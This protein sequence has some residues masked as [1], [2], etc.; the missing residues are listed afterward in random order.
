M[1]TRISLDRLGRAAQRWIATG[2]PWTNVYGL[3]R[4]LLAMGT[5]GT[6]TFSPAEVLFTPAAGLPPPPYCAGLSHASLFCVLP[7]DRLDLAR[8][9]AIAILLVTA[10]GWLPRYTA[11]PHWWVSFS[12]ASSISIPD[13]GD[14]VTTVLTLLLLPIALADRRRW[15]WT[16]PPGRPTAARPTATLVAMAATV[17]I[18]IQVAGIYLQASVAKLGVTE[19]RDGTALYYWLNDPL[20]G[21][22][23]W[24]RGLL[25]P[26]LSFGP[27][28][29][30]LTWGTMALEFCLAIA[31]VLPRRRWTPLLV[32]GLLLHSGIAV[33]MGLWSFALAMF[34]AL[35][36]YLRPWEWPFATP[37]LV[38]RSSAAVSRALSV[39]RNRW[40]ATRQP[41]LVQRRAES[42]QR[43]GQLPVR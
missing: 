29:A 43:T 40:A 19:W 32:G 18:R 41:S 4:T 39:G 34:A 36:L 27:T 17:L 11:L 37:A 23:V 5:L 8:I 31:L 3:A 35:I 13:G 14:Q 2:S 26:V 10:S 22:P 16:T 15:H 30:A 33:L 28:V 25:Q 12:V 7:A 20:F 6:L 38:S 42:G 21:A 1:L 24:L 9:I